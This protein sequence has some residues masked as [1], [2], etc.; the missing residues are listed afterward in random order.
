MAA[1]SPSLLMLLLLATA[2]CGGGGVAPA[3]A[4]PEAYVFPPAA[5]SAY[6]MERVAFLTRRQLA[7]ALANDTP[8]VDPTGTLRPEEIPPPTPV[9]CG[10]TLP[11]TAHRVVCAASPPVGGWVLEPPTRRRPAGTLVLLHGYVNDPQRYTTA[12]GALLRSAPDLFRSLRVVVPFAPRY[13]KQLEPGFLSDPHSWFDGNA[14]AAKLFPE[15]A[16]NLTTVEAV[17]ARMEGAPEDADRLGLFL[18]TRRIDIGGAMAA[19]VALVSTAPIDGVVVL[20][21]FVPA[22]RSMARLAAA[23]AVSRARRAYTLSFVA[24]SADTVVL[25]VL[26]EASSRIVR[27]ALRKAGRVTYE[28]LRGVTHSSFF[29]P[30]AD[31]SAVAGVL[32]RHFA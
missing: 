12:V 13:T 28:S 22:P 30:G 15:V 10:G 32:R 14:L 6:P 16:T 26:V 25:P 19:H 27:R 20:Q 4:T 17:E 21:G 11:A 23:G 31:A 8:T 3:A 5:P 29:F 18:S 7:A 2:L 24:G 1:T 9:T